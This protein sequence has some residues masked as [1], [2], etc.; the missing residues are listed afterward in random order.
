[1]LFHSIAPIHQ[2]LD[3]MEEER[4]Y[5][6]IVWKNRRLIVEPLA[7]GR[8]ARIVRLISSNPAD[9]LRPDL[10]PGTVIRLP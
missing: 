10:R 2:V 9:F 5:R 8:H 7:D 3:G 4:P 1:M 6:D